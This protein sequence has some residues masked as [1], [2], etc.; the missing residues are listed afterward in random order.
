MEPGFWAGVGAICAVLTVL[1][2]IL[3]ALLRHIKLMVR[4]ELM[5]WLSK[6]NGTYL[7]T[8]VYNENRA[9]VERR[10]ERLESRRVA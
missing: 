8:L 3:M 10:L 2:A 7:R 5:D 9:D 1:G 6:L 4:D